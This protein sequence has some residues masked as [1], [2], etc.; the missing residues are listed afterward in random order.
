MNVIIMKNTVNAFRI[1]NMQSIVQKQAT[2]RITFTKSL[3]MVNFPYITVTQ[4]F[5]LMLFFL[6]KTVYCVI[7]SDNKYLF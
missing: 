2:T 3:C 1:L 5:A 6:V 7:D 4:F